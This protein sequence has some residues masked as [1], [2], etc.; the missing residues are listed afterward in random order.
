[1]ALLIAQKEQRDCGLVAISNLLSV[2]DLYDAEG[3]YSQIRREQGYPEGDGFRCDL[4]DSP[5]RHLEIMQRMTRQ[6][7]GLV[8]DLV[9]PAV[10]L[11]RL[12]WTCWH[13]VTVIGYP[14]HGAPLQWHDG[15]AVLSVPFERR[16]PG[17]K[18]M[19]AYTIGGTGKLPWYYR[20]WGWLTRRI[21]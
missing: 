17:C 6:N 4:W 12:S 13:W 7:V 3:A 18:V 9:G 2:L 5:S 14:G 19:L 8:E 11:L 20:L 15:H 10:V 16:F 1:M 21:V